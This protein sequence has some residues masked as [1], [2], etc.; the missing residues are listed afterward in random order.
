[1]L[2]GF[3]V[4]YTVK[5]LWGEI[6]AMMHVNN[7][8]YLRWAESA[9]VEYFYKIGL[10]FDDFKKIGPILAWQDCKYIVP[11]TFPDEITIGIRTEEVRDDRYSLVCHF[12]SKKHQRLCAISR[13]TIV[14]YDYRKKQKVPLPAKWVAKI[15]EIDNPEL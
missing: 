2:E 4:N 11:I 7:V 8:Y 9:R 3:N 6:D 14:S 10:F 15:K 5:V 12:W 13:H 1:M